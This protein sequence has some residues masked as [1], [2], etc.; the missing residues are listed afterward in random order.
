[1]PQ[2]SMLYIPRSYFVNHLIKLSIII[3]FGFSHTVFAQTL[4]T[5]DPVA[6]EKKS[7]ICSAC[8]GKDGASINPVWPKHAGQ[9]P[10]YM[11]K[12]L[13]E[14]RAGFKDPTTA[15]RY[16][17]IMSAQ[18]SILSDQDILDLAAYFATKPISQGV[19]DKTLVKRGQEIYIGGDLARNIPACSACHSP[20]GI[21]NGPAKFP[22]MAGQHSVY[23]ASQLNNFKSGK[24]KNDIGRIMRDIAERLTD[25]EIKAVS[26]YIEGIQP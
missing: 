24:R 1:M 23:T 7:L 12:Q 4:P 10:E 6:G 13:Q 15:L 20:K 26:S 16:D 8:H 17:P 14:F 25:D 2:L 22:V 11:I 19:A 3:I 18:A 9:H 5:G 21:G